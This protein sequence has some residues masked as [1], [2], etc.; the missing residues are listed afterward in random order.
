MIGQREEKG[1]KGRVMK[2][3]REEAK[4]MRKRE[5]GEKIYQLHIIFIPSKS[6]SI[7]V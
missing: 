3:K 4:E 6:T 2:G 1:A 7:G 5:G